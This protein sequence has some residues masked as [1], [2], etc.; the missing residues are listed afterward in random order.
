MSVTD[1]NFTQKGKRGRMMI[2]GGKWGGAVARGVRLYIEWQWQVGTNLDFIEGNA[3]GLV[4]LEKSLQEVD[5]FGTL[6]MFVLAALLRVPSARWYLALAHEFGG[7]PVLVADGPI[8]CE[9]GG[10]AFG[11]I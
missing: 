2:F 6:R 3:L 10:T 1:I 4:L 9:F 7:V 8:Q 5:N 11:H